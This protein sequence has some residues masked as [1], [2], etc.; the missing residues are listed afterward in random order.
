[1]ECTCSS[2]IYNLDEGK[3]AV[4]TDPNSNGGGRDPDIELF[5]KVSEK[6]HSIVGIHKEGLCLT[7]VLLFY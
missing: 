1:M 2:F 6:E 4:M 7:N 5:V 3:S